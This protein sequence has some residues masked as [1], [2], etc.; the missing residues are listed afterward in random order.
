MFTI[1]VISLT[2]RFVGNT[3]KENIEDASYKKKLFL[4]VRLVLQI[5]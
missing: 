4:A 5:R 3:Y 2:I 1:S